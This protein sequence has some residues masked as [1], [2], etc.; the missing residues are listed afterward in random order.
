MFN[1]RESVSG[2]LGEPLP[3]TITQTIITVVTLI[4]VIHDKDQHKTE[5]DEVED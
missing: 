3:I 1:K 4:V 2:N 5:I